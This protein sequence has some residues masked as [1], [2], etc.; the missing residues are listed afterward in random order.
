MN[1]V[2][3]CTFSFFLLVL[4]LYHLALVVWWLR[5]GALI[6]APG[7][8]SWSGN[9]TSRLLVVIL[10]Q[11]RV[12]VMLTAMPPVF[13]IPTRSPMVDSFQWSF[14]TT[15]YWHEN[16]IKSREHCLI[17][18]WKVRGWHKKTRQGPALLYTGSLRIR[19][20][21]TALTTN[22]CSRNI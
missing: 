8:V 11:L 17:E 21:W 6:A 12:A 2:W 3:L 9:H 1:S 15:Q 7:F 5:L 22:H 19:I 20:D 10:W 18:R 13:Q 4:S 14:Q 16:P